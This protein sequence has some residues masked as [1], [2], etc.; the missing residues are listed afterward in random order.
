V[1]GAVTVYGTRAVAFASPEGAQITDVVAYSAHGEIASAV[2]F[3][4]PGG[5]AWFVSWLRPGQHQAARV[6][7]GSPPARRGMAW[8]ATAYLS[9]WGTCIPATDPQL[10]EVASRKSIT[11]LSASPSKCT[12]C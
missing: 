11:R 8:P 5:W 9:P 2:P 1:T 12:R 6:S 7:G 3:N 4:Q 10:V